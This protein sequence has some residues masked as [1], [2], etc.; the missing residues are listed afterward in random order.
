MAKW[1]CENCSA[2]FTRCKQGKR[3]I[4]FCSQQCYRDYMKASCFDYGKYWRGRVGANKGK[5]Y[6]SSPATEFKKGLTPANKCCVGTVRARKDKNGKL[7][8]W[9]KVAEP[10]KWKLRAVV[11]W[12]AKYGP[13]PNGLIVHHN[14]RDTMNDSITNLSAVSRAAHMLE[15]RSEFETKRLQGLR[16]KRISCP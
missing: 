10:N 2:G 8:A 5:H 12:E 4:R 14:D 13:L 6:R 3:K 11:E 7:R 15:H 1:I 9:V 16:R